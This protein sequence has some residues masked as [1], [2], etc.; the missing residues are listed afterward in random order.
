[1]LACGLTPGK[2]SDMGKVE[3]IFIFIFFLVMNQQIFNFSKCV[4]K[5]FSLFKSFVNKQSEI[6]LFYQAI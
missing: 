4:G 3:Y 5:M 6:F 2:E 1:M